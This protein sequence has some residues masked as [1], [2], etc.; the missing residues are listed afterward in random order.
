M[1]LANIFSFAAL[2][3]FTP[4]EAFIVVIIRTLLGAVFAGNMSQLLYSF[5]GGVVSM[6]ISSILTYT[7]HPKISVMAVSV[8]AAVAHNVTQ[9]LVYSLLTASTLTFAYMPYFALLGILSGA[10]VGGVTM[11][12]FRGVPQSVFEKVIRKKISV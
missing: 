6:A 8:I 1:G 12:I 2:I 11:I 7:A 9:I 4:L 10:I 5:T 3:M